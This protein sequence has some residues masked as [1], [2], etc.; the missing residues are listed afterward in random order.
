MFF[1]IFFF[2]TVPTAPKIF[3][4][5]YNIVKHFIDENTRRKVIVA[6]GRLQL[7]TCD[8]LYCYCCTLASWKEELQKYISPDNL[9]EYYGGTRREP[10][11]TC[12]KYVCMYCSIYSSV[13]CC[14]CMYLT[15]W[16]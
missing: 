4:V 10:D 13:T 5:A 9:P 16:V 8:I 14:N 2:S 3:P 1:D 11:P 6:G 7:V 12:S 15:T